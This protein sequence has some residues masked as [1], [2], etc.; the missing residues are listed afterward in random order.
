M[1][2]IAMKGRMKPPTQASTC[3]GM[4]AFCAI[5]PIASI[6]SIVPCGYSG[7]EP[8][9]ITVLRLIS[10]FSR[11]TSARRSRSSGSS[12]TFTPKYSLALNQATCAVVGSTISGAFTPR[13]ARARSR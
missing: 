12:R 9:I 8:R 5:A 13:F 4:P 6:G 2:F 11:F 3:S 10:P 7:A 1:P